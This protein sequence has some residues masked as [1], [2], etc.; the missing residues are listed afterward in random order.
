MIYVVTAAHDRYQIT[1]RFIESL[2]SQTYQ[3]IHLILVDDGSSDGTGEM[4]KERFPNSTVLR[5]DG[6]LWWGGALHMA[7]KWIRKNVADDRAYVMISNDDTQYLPDY[8]E[9]GVSLLDRYPDT[10]VA[11][12][13]YGIHSRE[14]MDGIFT[15]SFIDGTGKLMPPESESNCASTRSLFLRAGDWKRIGGMHP[16]LLPHYLSDFEFTIRAHKKGFHIRSFQE[17]C[18]TFDE[19]ATGDNVYDKLT[20]K[21]LFSKRSGCNP[22]YRISFIFLSTPIR[23]LPAHFGHQMRRYLQK[24]GLVKKIIEK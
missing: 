4:V 19:G 17:L 9:T 11:G 8:I 16:L 23:Y 6:N 5:G 24:L 7:Y 14:L 1:E 2:K 21:K 12:C 3:E 22:I 15:H 18:Y 13:G 20:V 10:L